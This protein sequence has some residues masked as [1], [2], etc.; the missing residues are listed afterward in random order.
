[1]DC[2]PVLIH[3]TR[4][5]S[6]EDMT[7]AQVNKFN[8]CIAYVPDADGEG[9]GMFLDGTAQYHSMDCVPGMDRG[10]K[11]LLVK[12]EGAEVVQIP[13]NTPEQCLFGQEFDVALLP[14][15]SADLSGKVV[16][17]GDL[18]VQ[19]RNAFS[20]E[21][22]RDLVLQG[23]LGP[24]FGKNT[25]QEKTFPDLKDITDPSVEVGLKIH[26][27]RFGE[28]DGDRLSLPLQF[29][30]LPV[31]AGLARFT[32]LEKREYDLVLAGPVGLRVRAVIRVPEGWKVAKL[33]D[34]RNLETPFAKFRVSAKADGGTVVF[35][36][37][38]M[39]T[40][41]R[42]SRDRYAD[43]RDLVAKVNA[44]ITEKIV[45]ERA[46]PAVPD[47]PPGGDGK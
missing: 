39:L 43:F 22:K 42:V 36:R 2:Y 31:F 21:G 19:I 13:W 45:L 38:A 4:G 10:A 18:S 32:S 6:E 23:I 5:R 47:A 24:S 8:H 26:V 37:E 9:R 14:D 28:A 41:N 30:N 33:P 11:V 20:V 25:V 46:A 40:A 1:M 29:V 7:L 12:P 34:E 3:A 16:F 35:E 17:T 27:D 15:G 44:S